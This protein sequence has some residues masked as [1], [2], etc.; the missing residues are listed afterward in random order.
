MLRSGTASSR[1]DS[2]EKWI[3]DT[4]ASHHLT[5]NVDDV[6]YLRPPPQGTE[7]VTTGDGTTFLDK[8]IGSLKLRFHMES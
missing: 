2:A 6:F 5:G 4:S 7:N 8:A 1:G 3:A